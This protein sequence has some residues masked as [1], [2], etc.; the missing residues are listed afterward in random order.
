M[1]LM[2]A[3]KSN[4]FS[5]LQDAAT[6]CVYSAYPVN[7]VIAQLQPYVIESKDFSD[8]HKA[9]ICIRLAE[10]DK[11]LVDGADEL[12]QVCARDVRRFVGVG[13]S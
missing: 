3:V 4:A 8:L 2:A 10:A 6:E 7:Q 1:K 9:K 5:K 11:K 12:L 13:V